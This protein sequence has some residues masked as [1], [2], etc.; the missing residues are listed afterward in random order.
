MTTTHNRVVVVML[1][2]HPKDALERSRL[3]TFS[4]K[5]FGW[6]CK[7]VTLKNDFS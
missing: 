7:F 1:E 2:L 5:K 6:F 3:T 4:V